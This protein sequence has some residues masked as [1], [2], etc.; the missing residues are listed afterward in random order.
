MTTLADLRRYAIQRT[1][2]PPTTLIGA[3]ERLG[4]VQADPIRAPARAQDLILRHRVAHYRAGDLERLYPE[5]EIEEDVFVNYGFLPRAHAALMHPRL[6]QFDQTSAR[7]AK[8]LLQFVRQRTEVH[9]R[10]VD[11]H[12]E[13]GKVANY[14]GGQSSATTFLLEHMHYKGLLRVARRENGIR[15]YAAR[16]ASEPAGKAEQRTRLDK[17]VDLAVQKYAPLTASGLGRLV[18]TL[19]SGA[20]QWRADFKAAL[21]RA[22]A[23]LA[24]A[25][26]D[27]V[28]WYWPAQERP[29]GWQGGEEARLLAPFDPIVWDR[30]RFEL[31][32]GWQYRFEAY[33][34]AAKRQFGYY[35]LPLLWKDR[36]AGW[37]NLKIEDGRLLAQL[38]FADGPAQKDRSLKRALEA[39]LG[40]VAIFLGVKV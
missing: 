17:L 12:F 39:E 13:H 32:W 22:K 30:A 15:I 10:E 33:T 28:E 9:P 14:W 8:A 20:P 23:R 21:A 11:E 34:P 35:A 31:L 40:R 1:L 36:M 4:F 7:R 19:R 2:F 24:H 37:A 5:L 6:Y 18:S 29:E 16:E 38:G 26:V 27:G 25:E 3:I